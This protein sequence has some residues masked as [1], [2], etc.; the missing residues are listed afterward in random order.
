MHYRADQLEN[1]MKLQIELRNK[2]LNTQLEMLNKLLPTLSKKILEIETKHRGKNSLKRNETVHAEYIDYLISINNSFSKE[3]DILK[4]VIKN[5]FEVTIPL[6][7]YLN[8]N[9]PILILINLF[10]SLIN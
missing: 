6:I 2:H 1:L 10:I 3:K 5:Q 8:I 4:R 9:Y 7:L